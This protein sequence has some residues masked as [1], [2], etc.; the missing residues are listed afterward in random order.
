[1]LQRYQLLQTGTVDPN[2]DLVKLAVLEDPDYDSNHGMSING[3]WGSWY[4]TVQATVQS[5]A[6]AYSQ[7]NNGQVP[8]NPS[9]VMP[10]LKNPLDPVTVQKYLNQ[11]KK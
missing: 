4:N 10:Y 1:M 8:T 7:A 3:A 5:A 11:L 2:A 6:G 9:Q